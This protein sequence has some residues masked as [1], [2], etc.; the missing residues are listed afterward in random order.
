MSSDPNSIIEPPT[1]VFTDSVDLPDEDPSSI[2][3]QEWTRSAL[4]Y[5]D[6][7]TLSPTLSPETNP[8]NDF[9]T[10][11]A[12]HPRYRVIQE[13]CSNPAG[14][15]IFHAE[16]RLM[17]RRVVLKTVPL[18]R[19][20]SPALVDLFIREIRATAY[21]KHPHIVTAYDAE[22]TA[23]YIF[24]AMELLEGQALSSVIRHNGPLNPIVACQYIYQAASA[25]DYA[26]DK[27]ILHR[28]VKPG[29]LVLVSDGPKSGDLVKLIDFGLAKPIEAI[30]TASEFD[31]T[32]SIVGT[33]QFMSPEHAMDPRSVSPLSDI[34]SL[35]RTFY[36]LLTAK[37]PYQTEGGLQAILR[38]V[39]GEN[40]VTP[41]AKIRNDV[42]KKII[43]IVEKMTAHNPQKRYQSCEEILAEL[44]EILDAQAKR[45]ARPRWWRF[46]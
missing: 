17:G 46:W 13:L 26:H 8:P 35:G 22:T 7:A 10:D 33:I 6:V 23:N 42:P 25:L 24:L 39:A 31:T 14:G 2:P 27:G 1:Q 34:F 19:G 3:V 45:T 30:N 43:Q 15:G 16:H 21:L 5:I 38:F 37:H 11:L 20:Y 9:C 32:E 44:R 36:Y 12:D 18:N 29:N 4:P 28:D 41:I 40:N